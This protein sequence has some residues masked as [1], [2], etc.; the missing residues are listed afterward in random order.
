[1]RR[2]GGAQD[3]LSEGRTDG[4]DDAIADED[5]DD[6][7]NEYA[8]TDT[9]GS[10]DDW[11]ERD[12]TK[13]D[14]AGEGGWKRNETVVATRVDGAG[15]H[16][17]SLPEKSAAILMIRAHRGARSQSDTGREIHNDKGGSGPAKTRLDRG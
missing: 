16:T 2:C 8:D 9:T 11:G 14:P 10:N 3:C 15:A 7:K 12:P 1:M 17:V 5:D 13:E 4:A 6:Q